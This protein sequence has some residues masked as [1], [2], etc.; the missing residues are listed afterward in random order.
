M[1]VRSVAAELEDIYRDFGLTVD[2]TALSVHSANGPRQR[3]KKSRVEMAKI[4]RDGTEIPP[5]VLEMDAAWYPVK[6]TNARAHSGPLIVT[7]WHAR[8]RLQTQAGIPIGTTPRSISNYPA[9]RDDAM[10]AV[11]LA[12]PQHCAR[13]E[14]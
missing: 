12:V 13:T 5:H 6:T 4:R 14:P 3:D 10:V 7:T 2:R 9:R 1:A 11:L 8:A